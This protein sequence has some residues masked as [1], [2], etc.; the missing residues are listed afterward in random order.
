M[1]LRGT[2]VQQHRPNMPQSV[3]VL[4]RAIALGARDF[5]AKPFGVGKN[6]LSVSD[7]E[8]QI[9]DSL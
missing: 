8:S 9:G 4:R 2:E 7:E 5:L 3:M 6:L 1:L